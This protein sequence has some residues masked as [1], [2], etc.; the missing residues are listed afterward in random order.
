MGNVQQKN[1]LQRY[2]VN[3]YWRK[4]KIRPGMNA[5]CIS[6]FFCLVGATA[7]SHLSVKNV[8]EIRNKQNKYSSISST[9]S[10]SHSLIL[11]KKNIFFLKENFGVLWFTYR[12][13]RTSKKKKK[14]SLPFTTNPG[15]LCFRRLQNMQSFQNL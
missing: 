6:A 8:M 4:I 1:I 7:V 14:L 15:C 9:P 11:V 3:I 5:R 13:L 2:S 10:C 12:R